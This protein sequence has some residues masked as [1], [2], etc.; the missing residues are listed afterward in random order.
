MGSAAIIG[1][2]VPVRRGEGPLD[3]LAIRAEDAHLVARH[4]RRLVAE[5]DH[6]AETIGLLAGAGPGAHSGSPGHEGSIV[7]ICS[8]PVMEFSDGLASLK[9]AVATGLGGLANVVKPPDGDEAKG[10]DEKSMVVIR[11]LIDELR[12][13]ETP[14]AEVNVVNKVP[15]SVLNVVK[16]QFKVMEGWMA[17]LIEVMRDRDASLEKLRKDLE[18]TRKNYEALIDRMEKGDREEG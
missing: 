6:A 17:P 8:G 15:L 13:S 1:L 2:A 7:W 3:G 9:D 14:P 12:K 5:R 18:K 11:G 16:Q 4:P 10:L